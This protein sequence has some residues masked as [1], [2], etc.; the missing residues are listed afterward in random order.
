[1]GLEVCAI[2]C[3]S[4]KISEQIQ[5]GVLLQLISSDT[6]ILNTEKI[7]KPSKTKSS[8]KH[9]ISTCRTSSTTVENIWWCQKA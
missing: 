6:T 3:A 2:E 1:M 8:W 7:L 9:I 4:Y 5:A